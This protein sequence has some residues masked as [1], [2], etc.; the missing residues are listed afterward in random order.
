[1]TAGLAQP[2]GDR[3]AEAHHG[4][5]GHRLDIRDTAHAVGAEQGAC[6]RD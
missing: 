2:G 3:H 1:M 6:H 5:A 4:G